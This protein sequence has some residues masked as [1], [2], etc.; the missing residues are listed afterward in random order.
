MQ[1]SKAVWLTSWITL[2]T[3]GLVQPAFAGFLC[4]EEK[5][6]K[7]IVNL[8]T[9]ATEASAAAP[10]G[11]TWQLKESYN[12]WAVFTDGNKDPRFAAC[13]REFEEDTGFLLGITCSMDET[14][15][16]IRSKLFYS[17]EG[18]FSVQI[19]SLPISDYQ[20]ITKIFGRC[21]VE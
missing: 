11:Q 13:R 7:V 2:C 3:V 21:T 10:R 9:E 20:T 12:G 16:D 18:M 14:R 15:F 4:I 17:S 6:E 1:N 8:A 19:W 5:V